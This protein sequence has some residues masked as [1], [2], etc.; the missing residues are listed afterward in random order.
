M[1]PASCLKESY[2][3]PKREG[4]R[5]HPLHGSCLVAKPRILAVLPNFQT[6]C[7]QAA[8]DKVAGSMWLE[9]KRWEGPCT[10]ITFL[11][12][13]RMD[14][15]AR[16]PPSYVT[17][18]DYFNSVSSNTQF[19]DKIFQKMIDAKAHHFLAWSNMIKLELTELPQ[20]NVGPS[21]LE[22]GIFHEKKHW[23]SPIDGHFHGGGVIK[24]GN[25][26]PMEILYK[27][28]L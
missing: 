14:E 11:V 8:T 4:P 25:G 19:S 26:K 1:F 16:F 5:N 3:F 12:C 15:N 7:H 18:Q 9:V 23:G 13:M 27:W 2:R 17:F 21:K 22:R 28:W 20:K 6:L 10:G 24:R